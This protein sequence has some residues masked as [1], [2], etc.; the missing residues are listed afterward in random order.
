[1]LRHK[2][3]LGATLTPSANP[4]EDVLVSTGLYNVVTEFEKCLYL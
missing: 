1:M 4:D 3:G 2:P